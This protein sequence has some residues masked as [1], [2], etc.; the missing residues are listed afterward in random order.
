LPGQIDCVCAISISDDRR[1]EDGGRDLIVEDAEV[2]EDGD[3][4]EDLDH[5]EHDGDDGDEEEDN[6]FDR[7]G[8]DVGIGVSLERNCFV[9]VVCVKPNYLEVQIFFKAN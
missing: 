7:F 1:L 3:V 8:G 5:V 6:R 4:A 9:L 2:E